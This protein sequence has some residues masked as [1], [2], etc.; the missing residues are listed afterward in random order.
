MQH[1]NHEAPSRL[2]TPVEPVPNPAEPA[3]RPRAAR[4]ARAGLMGLLALLAVGIP[5]DILDTPLFTREIPVRWW[6]YPVLAAT[7]ALTFAWF[8][9]QGP[10]PSEKAKRKPLAGVVLTVFAV[11]CPVCNKLVLVALGTSGAL[12][13]WAPLQPFLAVLSLALLVAAVAQRWR[14]R[15]C[16]DDT[17]SAE[18]GPGQNAAPPATAR[19]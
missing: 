16:S 9:I 17:C 8:A 2:D 7:A 18:G 14:R 11:G 12:G 3:T 1:S 10:P 4:Y 5:T 13:L 6:E 15:D 19:Q